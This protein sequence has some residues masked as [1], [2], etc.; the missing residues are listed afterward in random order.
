[1]CARAWCTP[2]HG[3]HC[4]Q[5]PTIARASAVGLL[6]TMRA[7]SPDTPAFT[8]FY[9]NPGTPAHACLHHAT[10]LTPGINTAPWSAHQRNGILPRACDFTS[11]S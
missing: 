1:M 3:P 9:Q 2:F 10:H 7:C 11:R 8:H 5:E 6:C 4:G